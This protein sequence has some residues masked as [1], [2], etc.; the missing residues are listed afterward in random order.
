M[1]RMRR[2][3]LPETEKKESSEKLTVVHVDREENIVHMKMGEHKITVVCKQY[4]SPEVFE[5]LQEAMI[6]IAIG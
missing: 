6:E 3:T 1:G 2:W 5:W 4:S